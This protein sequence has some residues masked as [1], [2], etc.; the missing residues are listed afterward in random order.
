MESWAAR[1]TEISCYADVQHTIE[2]PAHARTASAPHD[3]V[4]PVGDGVDIDTDPPHDPAH[5]A[6]CHPRQQCHRGLRT[7]HRKPGH[8]VIEVPYD[9]QATTDQAGWWCKGQLVPGRETHPRLVGHP[10]PALHLSRH[11]H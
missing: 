1:I 4:E 9:S 2:L 5:S 7:R 3:Q 10:R 11:R 6:P 8:R